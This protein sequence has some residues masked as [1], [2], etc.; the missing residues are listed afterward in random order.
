MCY[1][2]GPNNFILKGTTI[3]KLATPILRSRR[4]PTP[5]N[6]RESTELPRIWARIP[7]LQP[8]WRSMFAT[9]RR[10]RSRR[11]SE[12]ELIDEDVAVDVIGDECGAAEATADATLRCEIRAIGRHPCRMSSFRDLM[13]SE[14]GP[15]R[16]KSRPRS[17]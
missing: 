17:S 1:N 4:L 10:I 12:A 3:K 8:A 11:V 13:I 16:P 9:R 5:E 14:S 7:S 15:E 2:H 6:P